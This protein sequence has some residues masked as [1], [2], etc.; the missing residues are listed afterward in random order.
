MTTILAIA[1]LPGKSNGRCPDEAVAK[2]V[3]C[4]DIL[5]ILPRIYDTCADRTFCSSFFFCT[6]SILRKR[7]AEGIKW[8]V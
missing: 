2:N 1:I 4:I 5:Y 8:N 6:N 3:C 7:R